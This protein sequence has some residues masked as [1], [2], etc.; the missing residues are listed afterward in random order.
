MVRNKYPLPVLNSTFKLLQG[1]WFFTKLDLWNAYH[2]VRIREGDEWKTAF[3]THLGYYEYLVM[4]FGLT[5]APAIFQGLINDVLLDFL[6]MFVF[7]I[8]SSFFSSFLVAHASH[9]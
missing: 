5:N 2:L 9:V 1:A 6:N 4:P 7:W 8:K 3:N